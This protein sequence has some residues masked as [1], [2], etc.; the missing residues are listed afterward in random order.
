MQDDFG[1]F[2]KGISG[3]IHYNLANDRNNG[4]NGSGNG[5]GGS[6]GGCIVVIAVVL[7]LM[8]IGSLS[9]C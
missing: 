9:Q 5:G 4:G 6:G 2:G 7:I 8:F 1:Y 3:Y